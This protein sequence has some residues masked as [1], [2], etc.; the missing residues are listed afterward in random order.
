MVTKGGRNERC[1]CVPHGVAL[2]PAGHP[3]RAH[4]EEA[5]RRREWTGLTLRMHYLFFGRADTEVVGRSSESAQRLSL[6]WCLHLSSR[7]RSLEFTHSS[8]RPMSFAV[9]STASLRAPVAAVR[10]DASAR[11]RTTRVTVGRTTV[12]TSLA[13]PSRDVAPTRSSMHIDAQLCP[14][15]PSTLTPL[16][17]HHL[18][19]P[20]THRRPS[21]LRIP[22]SARPS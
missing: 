4:T 22:P 9:A 16:T 3:R 1:A 13:H 2:V 5:A 18:R 11:C 19:Y 12:N 20:S 10:G 6:I 21:P 14:Q 7:P 15:H 8:S 17:T